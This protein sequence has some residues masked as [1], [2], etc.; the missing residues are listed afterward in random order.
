[1]SPY[2]T[3]RLCRIKFRVFI[4]FD[5][6]PRNL[7]SNSPT[8]TCLLLLVDWEILFERVMMRYELEIMFTASVTRSRGLTRGEIGVHFQCLGDLH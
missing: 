6:K 3:N 1:M 4:D 7:L 8:R 2:K 5:E